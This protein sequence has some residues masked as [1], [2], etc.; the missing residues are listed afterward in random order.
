MMK[1]KLFLIVTF[2]IGF[3]INRTILDSDWWLIFD[4]LSACGYVIGIGFI[5]K[6]VSGLYKEYT[7][8]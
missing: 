5:Y 3:T 1:F 6:G 8:E 7:Q 2:I 4:A